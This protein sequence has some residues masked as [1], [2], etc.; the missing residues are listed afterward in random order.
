MVITV[1]HS[2]LNDCDVYKHWLRMIMVVVK[3]SVLCNKEFLNLSG[4]GLVIKN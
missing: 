1:S 4:Q 3:V 2:A